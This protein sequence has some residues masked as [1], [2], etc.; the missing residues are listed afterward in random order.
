MI[1]HRPS[2]MPPA[3]CKPYYSINL[4]GTPMR[5]RKPVFAA[6]LALSLL[7]GC[8]PQQILTTQGYQDKIV[9]ACVIVMASPWARPWVATVCGTEASIARFAL[10]P[11]ILAWLSGIADRVKAG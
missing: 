8:T 1:T 9:Q 11:T 4:K 3:A 7:A 10:D 2:S 6:A 5:L